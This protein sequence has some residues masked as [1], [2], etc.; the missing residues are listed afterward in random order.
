M[1]GK[2]HTKEA[3]L[4]NSIAH[5]G[6]KQSAETIEKR[7]GGLRGKHLSEEHRLKISN[8]NKGR[9]LSLISDEGRKRL[10][11]Q[12]KNRIITQD[13]RDKISKAQK[14]KI[15]SQATRQKLSASHIGQKSYWKNKHRDS[16]TCEKISNTL[17]NKPRY[18][19]RIVYKINNVLFTGLNEGA[20]YFNVT[21]SCMSLWIKQ[22]RTK[23]GDLIDIVIDNQLV[24]K[25]S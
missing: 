13:T 15:V 16:E 20:E 12:M 11:E 23:N 24:K 6:K 9:K 14:G 5:K 3:K 7:I 10:S 2:H 19:R 4:K 22:G 21:K 17:S 18:N 25:K 8:A 1:Y